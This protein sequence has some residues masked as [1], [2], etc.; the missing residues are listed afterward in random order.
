MRPVGPHP[1]GQFQTWV[2]VEYFAK[3]YEWFVQKRSPLTVLI[4]PLSKHEVLDHTTRAVFMGKSYDLKT[5]TLREFI[6]NLKS[7]H[8]HVKLG[9]AKPGN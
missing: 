5:D 1:V 9:Y 3:L 8:E 2:P 4:H 6:P 7:E